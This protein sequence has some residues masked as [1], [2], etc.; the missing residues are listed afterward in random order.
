MQAMRCARCRPCPV[1]RSQRRWCC[2]TAAWT[3]WRQPHTPITRWT[4][5]LAACR[6]GRPRASARRVMAEFTGGASAYAVSTYVGLG[7]SLVCKG[8]NQVRVRSP[9]VC[10]PSTE[11]LADLL[12]QPEQIIVLAILC[13]RSCDVVV[14]LDVGCGASGRPAADAAEPSPEAEAASEGAQGGLDEAR[15]DL[16]SGLAGS[17]FSPGDPQVY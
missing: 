6:G 9:A 10:P 8:S 2:W 11:G 12:F 3:W 14:P 1:R 5:H 16:E 15:R 7:Q 17:L 13:C 4:A